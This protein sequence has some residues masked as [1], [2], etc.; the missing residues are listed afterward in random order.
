MEQAL[1]EG[2][3]HCRSLRGRYRR[4]HR[5]QRPRDDAH[6]AAPH[7]RLHRR[8]HRQDAL[9]RSRLQLCEPR[10]RRPSRHDALLHRNAAVVAEEERHEAAHVET[11]G[12]Q[13]LRDVLIALIPALI[14]SVIIFGFRSLRHLHRGAEAAPPQSYRFAAPFPKKKV[15]KILFYYI[16]QY[17]IIQ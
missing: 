13:R 12:G 1:Q 7:R 5:L 11:G 17:D 16:M 2:A 3:D 8:H 9:R 4:A 6:L 14:A 10:A 15:Y